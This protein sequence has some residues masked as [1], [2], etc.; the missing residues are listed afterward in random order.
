M[1]LVAWYSACDKYLKGMQNYSSVWG[2]PSLCLCSSDVA[3]MNKELVNT[4][5]KHR[6]NSDIADKKAGMRDIEDKTIRL[7]KKMRNEVGGAFGRVTREWD[8]WRLQ[9]LKRNWI[10]GACN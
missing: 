2:R 8:G 7:G 9:L 10:S 4:M 3:Q 6:K 1:D 5:K